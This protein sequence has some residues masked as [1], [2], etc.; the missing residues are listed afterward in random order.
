MSAHTPGPW[1]IDPRADT[2]VT[3]MA[4]RGICSAGGY[5]TNGIPP[6]ILNAEHAANARLIAA[7]PELLTLAECVAEHFDGTDSPLGRAARAVVAMARG[8]E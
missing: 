4:G 5:Q 3:T 6:D 8:G 7:A 1:L 2:H